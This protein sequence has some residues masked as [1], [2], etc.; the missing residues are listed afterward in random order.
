MPRVEQSER[1]LVEQ[2]LASEQFECAT[3]CVPVSDMSSLLHAVNEKPQLNAR[4]RE[5]DIDPGLLGA[6]HDGIDPLAPVV[7]E[8]T[9]DLVVRSAFA[10]PLLAC[11][12]ALR[13]DSRI[14]DAGWLVVGAE[15][16]RHAI[17]GGGISVVDVLRLRSL[18]LGEHKQRPLAW[19]F[20]DGTT[21]WPAAAATSHRPT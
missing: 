21:W 16:D 6:L 8:D 7:V 12:G 13:L 15:G 20:R 3:L 2:L 14:D 17:S 11:S 4:V 18:T 10:A 1:A 5:G 9:P 19:L